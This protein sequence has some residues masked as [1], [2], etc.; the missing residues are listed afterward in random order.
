[1]ADA[2]GGSQAAPK[3]FDP[4][5]LGRGQA[6]PPPPDRSSVRHP[7]VANS[8]VRLYREELGHGLRMI[9]PAG[10][11]RL[12]SFVPLTNRSNAS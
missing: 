7:A 6:A 11:D 8:S 1:M 10:F 3:T 9:W 4:A 2:F 12:L 5:I